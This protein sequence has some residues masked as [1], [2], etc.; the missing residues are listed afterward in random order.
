MGLIHVLFVLEAVMLFAIPPHYGIVYP[1]QYHLYYPNRLS[2]FVEAYSAAFAFQAIATLLLHFR[3][4]VMAL[5]AA[6]VALVLTLLTYNPTAYD[7]SF[8]EWALL[9]VVGLLHASTQFSG[10][11]ELLPLVTEMAIIVVAVRFL[12]AEVRA[13]EVFAE[14]VPE[15]V[16]D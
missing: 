1:R 9:N 10:V 14:T 11:C 3:R 7:I 6:L 5:I 8:P 4:S 16:K 2:L 13:T 15:Q 12:S